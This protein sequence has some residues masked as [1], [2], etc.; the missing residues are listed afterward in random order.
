MKKKYKLMLTGAILALIP[1]ISVIHRTDK[2][3]VNT[4]QVEKT[5]FQDTI[6]ENGSVVSA[7]KVTLSAELNGVVLTAIKENTPVVQGQEVLTIDSSQIEHQIAQLRGNLQ[8]IQGQKEMSTPSVYQSQI[9]AQKLEIESTKVTMQDLEKNIQDA[10][11]LYEAG[12]ISKSELDNLELS[13]EQL[14]IKK[15]A[16]EKQLNLIYEQSK[17]KSG[18]DKMY[19]GQ[20]KSVLENMKLLENQK[21]KS[22]LRSP[23]NGVV[24]EILVKPGE[25]AQLQSP[26]V[27]IIN[28]DC[29]QI[30]SYVL[31]DDVIYLH[32]G[33]KVNIRQETNSEDL[34]GTGIISEI[35]AYATE[36]RSGLGLDEKKVK[37][38][39]SIQ[40]KGTLN[41]SANYDVLLDFVLKEMKDVIT[42][43]KSAMFHSKDGKD[44]VFVVKNG[45]AVIQE[46]AVAYESNS[47][48]V[49][50]EGLEEGDEV[51]KDP[52][53]EGL[54][55]N[56]AVKSEQKAK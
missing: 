26:V 54:K 46:V 31:T 41:I 37:V 7:D 40:D 10:K 4:E 23:I 50:E 28:K 21:Q 25:L 35:S 16:P 3:T 22:V 24:S 52:N 9:E 27:T 33:D 2:L 34:C 53:I 13:Y 32:V 49:I 48:Y 11:L 29:L 30:E 42:I 36:Q 6:E 8:S 5:D 39:V 1:G 47:K 56:I 18:T 14:Q 55:E 20:Q 15:N 51:I 19:D 44:A 45:K 43:P 12:S 38:T 17:P